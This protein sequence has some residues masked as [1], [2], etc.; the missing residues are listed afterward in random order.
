MTKEYRTA[1]SMLLILRWRTS[2]WSISNTLIIFKI[3]PGI[4][5]EIIFKTTFDP[6]IFASTSATGELQHAPSSLTC[7]NPIKGQSSWGGVSCS[8][9][10]LGLGAGLGLRLFLLFLDSKDW[11]TWCNSL[12]NSIAPPIIDAWS[13]YKNSPWNNENPN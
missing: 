13:P 4:R 9:G 3:W 10:G 2:N 12:I 5:F 6:E 8:C 1:S 11:R 7:S